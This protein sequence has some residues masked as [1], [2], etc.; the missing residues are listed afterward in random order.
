MRRFLPYPDKYCV[1]PIDFAICADYRYVK[2][3][4]NCL[5]RACAAAG[6]EVC[7][8]KSV[9]Y[10]YV[11]GME[12]VPWQ[13]IIKEFEMPCR[14]ALIRGA[15]YGWK[16]SKPC[17][18]LSP[19][20]LPTIICWAA[21]YCAP[22]IEDRQLMRAFRDLEREGLFFEIHPGLF[23]A[24]TF[25]CSFEPAFLR[26]IE[27]SRVFGLWQKWTS[28]F[29]RTFAGKWRRYGLC[30][31]QGYYRPRSSSFGICLGKSCDWYVRGARTCDRGREFA[32]LRRA[33]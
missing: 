16:S 7:P 20:D 27:A 4:L 9:A 24:P 33:A 14:A 25:Y 19:Y 30:A 31:G 23:N 8:A 11:F 5:V 28:D 15:V 26:E 10:R 2:L 32:I 3:C 18:W 13:P 6:S 22:E 17:Q 21:S 29:D 12:S 1:R